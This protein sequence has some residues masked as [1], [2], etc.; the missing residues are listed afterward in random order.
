L[1]KL[2][3]KGCQYTL[4]ALTFVV[5]DKEKERFQAK[6][7]C[8][9]AEIPESFTRKVLQALVQ[10]GFL[11][12]HRGP[13]GGYSLTRDP[14]EITVLEVIQAVEGEDTFDHCILGFD[15]CSGE[16]PCPL[17]ELWVDSKRNLLDNLS[18]TT[19]D[20][21]ADLTLRRKMLVDGEK[22]RRETTTRGTASK[23]AKPAK[24]AQKV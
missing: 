24:R 13:G 23:S 6:D 16:N 3:S 14:S 7:I 20:Q 15:E 18:G 4:R 11:H 21:L 10:G 8:E 19:L 17:H 1:L 5:A 12:A 22:R 9:R 2:Y